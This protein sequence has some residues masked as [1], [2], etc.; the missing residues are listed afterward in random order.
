MLTI[1]IKTFERPYCINRLIE[2]IFHYYPK[3][4]IMVAD[5][6]R[7]PIEIDNVEYHKLSFNSGIS[8]GRNFLLN[9]VKTRYFL[10]L[11][12]DFI[13]T[14]NTNLDTLLGI[15]E[16]NDVDLIA[17]DILENSKLRG[18]SGIGVMRLE[19][20]TLYI[21]RKRYLADFKNYYTCDFVPNF[22][23]ADA[24]RV[25]Q[26]GAWDNELKVQEHWAFFIR[27]EAK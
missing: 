8:Y 12:D 2:S 16:Q 3:M 6:S 26:A 17:G 18:L 23:M 19:G 11:D 24:R 22:F 4:I 1:V 7:D 13:F 25:V 21:T 5:D 15:L 10:L 9:R 20:R 27:S 14:E